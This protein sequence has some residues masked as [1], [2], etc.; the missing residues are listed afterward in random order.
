[1]LAFLRISRINSDIALVLV[2][3]ECV[4]INVVRALADILATILGTILLLSS[5]LLPLTFL[6]EGGL[7][8]ILNFCMPF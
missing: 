3:A 4:H 8:T 1:M 5:S 2:R 7:P 6:P